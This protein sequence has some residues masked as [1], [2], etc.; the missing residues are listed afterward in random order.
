[1]HTRGVNYGC[2][3]KGLESIIPYLY[4]I[5]LNYIIIF[6]FVNHET[7]FSVFFDEYKL[8]KNCIYMK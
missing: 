8:Q 4:C 3:F 7:F 6:T 1:M 5:I 2:K